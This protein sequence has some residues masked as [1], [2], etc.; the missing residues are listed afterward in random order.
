MKLK[1]LP[2]DLGG[3]RDLDGHCRARI[4]LEFTRLVAPI[5]G[6]AGR[7]NSKWVLSSAR[8][9][10]PHG[11]WLSLDAADAPLLKVLNGIKLGV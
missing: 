11:A 3:V 1:G 9:A 10:D 6:I 8:L 5:D 4:N 2:R 7:R